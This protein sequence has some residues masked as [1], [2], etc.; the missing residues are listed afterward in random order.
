M[1]ILR[2]LLL[3]LALNSSSAVQWKK[4]L[5]DKDTDRK[6]TAC[7]TQMAKSLVA[8]DE[9]REELTAER[10]QARTDHKLALDEIERMTKELEDNK[11]K[12]T[13]RIVQLGN[14]LK[15]ATTQLEDIESKVGQTI[16]K[17]TKE[18]QDSESAIKEESDTALADL[19][20][21]FGKKIEQ[22]QKDVSKLEEEKDIEIE[23]NK[24]ETAKRISEKEQQLIDLK[25]QKDK[26]IKLL[27][28]KLNDEKEVV[29]KELIGKKERVRQELEK[30]REGLVKGHSKVVNELKTAMETKEKEAMD[31]IRTKEIELEN[32]MNKLQQD[33]KTLV[34]ENEG[35]Y[36][37][38][39]KELISSMEKLQGDHSKL[40]EHITGLE[41]KYAEASKEVEEWQA[42]FKARSYCNL[43]HIQEDTAAT[44]SA[45]ATA[46][47]KLASEQAVIAARIAS[48]AAEPHIETSRKFLNQ[49]YDEHLKETVDVHVSPFYETHIKPTVSKISELVTSGFGNVKQLSSNS[50]KRA[51][52]EFKA[53]CIGFKAHLRQANFPKF[54]RDF[55]R[56]K[57]KEPEQT[58]DR[59]FMAVLLIFVIIFRR[60]LWR[61]AKRVVYFPFWVMW[62]LTPLP[63]LF[64]RKRS[65]S[66]EPIKSEN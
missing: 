14:E 56:Q 50:R 55:V 36:S 1:I 2:L 7:D 42:T 28:D 27:H 43:T 31:K 22:L 48:K 60:V 4:L 47:S 63:L 9:E 53:S 34:E 17:M 33:A 38:Q 19:R 58:V 51:I 25:A 29:V 35:N 39:I 66:A 44:V 15:E 61:T 23:K 11:L 3:L 20:T 57:C 49:K 52:E 18:R 10:D 12:L 24:N 65:N 6:A 45:A 40:E 32:K 30:E 46:A 54:F 13:N 16:S 62:Y 59:F 21:D 26:E 41:L 8:A 37:M 64:G 5:G